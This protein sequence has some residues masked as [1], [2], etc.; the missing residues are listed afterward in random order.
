MDHREKMMKLSQKQHLSKKFYNYKNITVDENK[1]D[2]YI[3]VIKNNTTNS[4][5]V[6]III[7]KVRT[8]FVGKYESIENIKKRAR[9]FILDLIQ[10]QRDQ[11]AGNP[12][13]SLLP[14]TQG[15]LCEELG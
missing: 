8:T 15:N 7:N 6:R 9:N 10:W 12:L 11:I 13:E 5:Y 2:D 1:I 3:H 4:E 14:L